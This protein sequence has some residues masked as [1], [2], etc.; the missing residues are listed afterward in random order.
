MKRAL[1]LLPIGLS[2][3]ALALAGC[4]SDDQSVSLDNTWARTS[5]AGQTTGA[6]YFD[7]TVDQNDTL[8]SASVPASIAADA[9]VHEVV[10]AEMDD[11][12]AVEGS[13]SMDDMTCE[14]IIAEHTENSAEH[15][16]D[17]DDMDSE[18]MTDMD[19]IADM[20]C[21]EIIAE[22]N[23][24]SDED[25]ADMD[26]EEMAGMGAMTM[27]ELTD[28]LALTAGE[29]VSFEP[30]SYHVMLLD[31]V[32]PLEAGDEVEVTLE[33]AESG[34]ITTTVEVAESAP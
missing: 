32:E 17:M 29:T 7:L 20:T 27:Q 15:M 34:S 22:H 18:E 30:G 24:M 8:L 25:M 19:D 21:E 5:A 26:A 6:I 4:G 11:S 14:E 3:G 23:E 16:D 33:F 31:L 1:T 12:D 9:Q 13:D 28:G 2:L 10:M